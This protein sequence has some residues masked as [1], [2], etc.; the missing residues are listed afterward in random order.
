VD[1]AAADRGIEDAETAKRLLADTSPVAIWY[2][3]GAYLLAA[4]AYRAAGLEEKYQRARALALKEADA[5]EPFKHMPEAAFLRTFCYWC[6]DKKDRTLD[7]LRTLARQEDA[8]LVAYEFALLLCWRGSPDDLRA[9]RPILQRSSGQAPMAVLNCLAAAELEGREAA[10]ECYP[11]EVPQKTGGTSRVYFD[12]IPLLLGRPDLVRAAA[13][14]DRQ[15]DLHFRP[16]EEAFFHAALDSLAGSGSE[17]ALLRAAAGSQRN[18]CEARY[19][20]GLRRLAEGDR[21]GAREQ[22]RLAV[23]TTFPNVFA[24][25]FSILFLQRLE[26]DPAWPPW[27][28][29]KK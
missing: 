7:E 11:R 25:D 9:A 16:S 27:I 3:A 24:H 10:L 14:A 17:A 13:R 29:A 15:R 6:F 23:A 22:F 21:A 28:P 20:L 2:C 12:S 18:E 1:V 19:F 8:P 5:L 26:R 4:H